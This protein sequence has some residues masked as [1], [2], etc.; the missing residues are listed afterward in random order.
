MKILFVSRLE[1]WVRAVRTI[2]KY[3]ELGQ[4]LGHEVAV[5][6]EPRDDLPSVPHSRDVKQ[7]DFAIFVIYETA[8]FPDLPHL[9]HLLDR[10]PKE[11][12]IIIDCTGVYN[13]TITVEHDCNHWVKLNG[14]HDWEWIEGLAAVASR[15]LQPT[16]TPLRDDVTSFLFFGYDPTAVARPYCSP[17][18]AAESWLGRKGAK[19][20]DILYVGH[21]WQR[22]TQLKYFLEAIEPRRSRFGTTELRGWA[23]DHRP[24]WAIANGID[25]LDVDL[26]LLERIGVKTGGPVMF[27]EVIALQSLARFCPVFHRPL[28]NELGL[29]TNRTFETFCSDTIPLLM[30]PEQIVEKIHG[31]AALRLIRDEDLAAQL[32]DMMHRPEFYWDAVLKTRAHLAAHHSYE[33]RFEELLAILDMT[34]RRQRGQDASK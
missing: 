5:F 25:G 28:F 7:F 30:L 19:P 27:D 16:L 8:D 12:R 26:A 31:S 4:Q 23:W 10:I 21:N 14:H 24:D 15:I 29:V 1:R 34:A 9:A 18:E 17:Q 2:T 13:K 6:G 11:R 33:R 32:D 20:Y 3:V 22:W